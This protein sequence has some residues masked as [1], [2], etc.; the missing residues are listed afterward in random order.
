MI[1]G[2]VF[3]FALVWVPLRS[4]ASFLILNSTGCPLEEYI[5]DELTL[6]AGQAVAARGGVAAMEHAGTR[7]RRGLPVAGSGN[8][9]MP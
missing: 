2:I 1:A 6:R 3:L 5:S 9:V 7:Y 8:R 4:P